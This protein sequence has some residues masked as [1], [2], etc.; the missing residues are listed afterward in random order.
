M[1]GADGA[2]RRQCI[3]NRPHF[4][5]LPISL[6]R[7]RCLRRLVGISIGLYRFRDV[8]QLVGIS[9]GLRR[10]R[11]VW[12]F[13]GISISLHRFRDVWQLV[14][15]SIGLHRFRGVLYD[16]GFGGQFIF[17][18]GFV[19]HGWR[20]IIVLRRRAVSQWEPSG[21]YVASDARG[22]VCSPGIE[23][24]RVRC[25]ARCSPYLERGVSNGWNPGRQH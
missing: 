20:I 1:S 12:Q 23:R 4:V 13:V 6:H 22:L 2:Q 9:I 24:A 3:F 16:T 10:F 14:G 17:Q 5:R 18:H 15:I 21:E 19:Q 11:D 25:A 8:W 7:F